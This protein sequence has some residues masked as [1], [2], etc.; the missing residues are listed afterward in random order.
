MLQERFAKLY[1]SLSKTFAAFPVLLDNKFYHYAESNQTFANRFEKWEI[2]SLNDL[3]NI[4]GNQKCGLVLFRSGT[5]ENEVL[6][7]F[8]HPRAFRILIKTKMS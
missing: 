1:S 7:V 2:I 5:A 8:V 3:L 4:Q 6:K